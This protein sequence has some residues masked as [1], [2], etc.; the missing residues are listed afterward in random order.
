MNDNILSLQNG[1]LN[2]KRTTVI[3]CWHINKNESDAMWRLY[4][5]D[6]EGVAIQSTTEKVYKT[7]DEIPGIIGLSRIRYLNYERDIWYHPIEYPHWAYNTYTPILHKRIEFV[8]ENEF[9][10]FCEIKDAED[11]DYYW[12]NQPN[13]KGKFI[14]LN[15]NTLIE[16]IYLPPTLDKITSLKIEKLSKDLGYNF[17]FINSKLSE[18]PWY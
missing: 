7:I 13:H 15:L 4:L 3:N 9:R 12:D 10:L 17:S 11:D 5:K 14:Q 6:N 16:K 18:E 8:H 1:H 2:F